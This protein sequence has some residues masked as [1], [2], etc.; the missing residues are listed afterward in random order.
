[1]AARPIAL[2]TLLLLLPAKAH[3]YRPFDSTDAAVAE[4]GDLELEIGPVGYL[5]IGR[6]QF[7]VL[8]AL[9]INYGFLPG[10]ELVLQ[11]EQDLALGRLP[12]GVPRSQLSNTSL[13]AK[14]VLRPG[15]LQDARGPSI[16]SEFG[17]LLPT[18]PLIR[19]GVGFWL[20]GIGSFRA[21]EVTFHLNLAF[22]MTRDLRPG[23][24]DG[25]IIEGPG[26]WPVRPVAELLGEYDGN[27]YWQAT[28]L[29][30]LI[31]AFSE[32]VQF[33]AAFRAGDSSG[34]FVREVRLG[35]TWAIPVGPKAPHP[36]EPRSETAWALPRE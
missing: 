29:A 18:W 19:P 1:M 27:R 21:S 10:W 20:A 32:E 36:A 9:V 25:L 12:D 17:L 6:L 8:P 16:A 15:F 4:R 26:K 22:Q 2:S 5:G 7:L 35:V 28:G 23:T 30:G 14:H 13:T 24:Q 11:G 33:D 3:A 31:W 34:G